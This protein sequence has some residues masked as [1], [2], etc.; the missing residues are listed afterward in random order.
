MLVLTG[1]KNWCVVMCIAS[2]TLVFK[3]R[4]KVYCEVNNFKEGY[5]MQCGTSIVIGVQ[6]GMYTTLL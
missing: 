4:N 5:V 2:D 1:K 3:I 6:V